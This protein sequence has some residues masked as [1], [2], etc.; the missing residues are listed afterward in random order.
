MNTPSS[1]V[2]KLHHVPMFI[3][4]EENSDLSSSKAPTFLVDEKSQLLFN[5]TNTTPLESEE[6]KNLNSFENCNELLS[7]PYVMIHPLIQNKA[8]NSNDKDK[9]K[10]ISYQPPILPSRVPKLSNFTNKFG[11]NFDLN[12]SIFEPPS[13]KKPETKNISLPIPAYE[14]KTLDSPKLSPSGSNVQIPPISLLTPLPIVVG[15]P[16]GLDRNIQ[17]STSSVSDGMGF[18]NSQ[19]LIQSPEGKE[20]DRIIGKVPIPK[21][22]LKQEPPKR[23]GSFQNYAPVVKP[24]SSAPKNGSRIEAE[25]YIAQYASL[26]VEKESLAEALT[27]VRKN[28][29]DCIGSLLNPINSQNFIF[30]GKVG[31]LIFPPYPVTEELIAII[32]NRFNFAEVFIKLDIYLLILLC[33]PYEVNVNNI[34]EFA[35][36]G[37]APTC[38]CT[39]KDEGYIQVLQYIRTTEEVPQTLTEGATAPKGKFKIKQY[40]PLSNYRFYH[41]IEEFDGMEFT[42]ATRQLCIE[43]AT[44]KMYPAIALITRAI[45]GSKT[46]YFGRTS[47]DEFAKKLKLDK[48]GGYSGNQGVWLKYVEKGKNKQEKWPIFAP[49]INNSFPL[50]SEQIESIPY[51]LDKG[52]KS[53]DNIF[54]VFPGFAA[55]FQ[56]NMT[57]EEAEEICK[58][59]LNHIKEV[60]CNDNIDQYNYDLEFLAKGIRDQVKASICTIL[61]G[62][63]GIGK[64]FPVDIIGQFVFG[65]KVYEQVATLDHVLGNFN[66]VLAN[67]MMILVNEVGNVGDSKTGDKEAQRLKS[68]ITDRKLGMSIKYENFRTIQN[69]VTYI[70][71][72]NNPQP[73]K[74]EKGPRRYNF[75]KCNPKYKGNKAYF[76][77]LADKCCNQKFGDALYTFFRLHPS[78]VNLQETPQTEALAL[79]IEMSRSSNSAFFEEIINGEV[80]FETKHLTFNKD[81]LHNGVLKSSAHDKNIYIHLPNIYLEYYLHW[82]S[83]NGGAIQVWSKTT[84][85]KNVNEDYFESHIEKKYAFGSKS[86]L[87][88]YMFRPELYDEYFVKHGEIVKTMR[89]YIDYCLSIQ[90]E[91]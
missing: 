71:T 55:T 43:A 35:I 48:W 26:E 16:T 39:V 87:T 36:N 11:K 8:P 41:Y 2:E 79:A 85:A 20:L 33:L 83:T 63:K 53:D 74:I 54:N 42:Y 84:L 52:Y 67:K 34:N 51:H 60:W 76:D 21:P 1:V 72:T 69:F 59:L 6:N 23:N 44:K 7:E 61:S 30:Q 77:N 18:L 81:S 12:D 24:F 73:I 45:T 82:H 65:D 90:V 64:T 5:E 10:L 46:A 75:K 66:S 22:E 68:Q 47:A 3:S 91:A 9:G 62:D 78:T 58:P 14:E 37:I 38:V 28:Y 49:L 70:I 31:F 88:Y 80:V 4:L 29:I 56:P 57:Y 17:Y 50:L 86:K 15:I 25:A 27:P 13:F 32:K 19:T 40:T 89:Q